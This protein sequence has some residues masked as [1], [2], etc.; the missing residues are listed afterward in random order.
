MK[1][2]DNAEDN[3]SSVLSKSKSPN[4]SI[5]PKKQKTKIGFSPRSFYKT[6]ASHGDK[7]NK[8]I[9]DANNSFSIKRNRSKR[10]LN[11]KLNE[12]HELVKIEILEYVKQ[13]GNYVDYVS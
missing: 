7:I 1:A 3:I 11:Q 4:K 13:E 12:N 5:T 2:V 10:D 9:N 8:L 6:S